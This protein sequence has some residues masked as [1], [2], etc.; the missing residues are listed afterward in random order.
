MIVVSNTSPILNLAAIGRLEILRALFGTVSIP[1]AV[2][3]EFEEASAGLPESGRAL[4]LWIEDAPSPPRE[5]VIPLSAFL[6]PGEAESIAS[7]AELKAGLLL[8]DE[9]RGRQM[10]RDM[11][12]TVMGLLGVLAAAKLRGFVPLVKPVLDDLVK[13]AGF[14]VSSDLYAA[15]LAQAGE[16]PSSAPLGPQ[17]P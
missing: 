9:R 3:A 5:V 15:V 7:A 2:R 11:G 8:M 17:D 14:W 1:P 16:A 10:A 4:P 13:R 6:H 12:L